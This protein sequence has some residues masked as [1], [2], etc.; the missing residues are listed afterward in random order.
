M[1]SRSNTVFASGW[2][3]APTGSPVRHRTF[4]TPST[5]AAKEVALDGDTVAV[6]ARYLK[7]GLQTALPYQRRKGER[8][9][10]HVGARVVGEVY[11]VHQPAQDVRPGQGVRHIH[12]LGRIDLR[13]NDEIAGLKKL[14]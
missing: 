13:G 4:S 10:A 12:A 8:T 7:D 3:P 5:W 1:E 2:S 14:G 9:H 11:G 6:S